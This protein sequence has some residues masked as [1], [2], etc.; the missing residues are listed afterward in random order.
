VGEAL[1]AGTNCDALAVAAVVE[2]EDV[3]AEVVEAREGWD[4]VG[5]GAVAVGEEEDS[6]VGVA[7]A[8]IG[9]NPPTGEL[10]DGGLIGT[11]ADEL[12]RNAGDRGWVAGRAG[13]VQD[14]L[15]LAL[16]EEQAKGEIAAE[17]CGKNGEADGLQPV[18]ALALFYDFKD[19]TPIGADGCRAELTMTFAFKN[20]LSAVLFEQ[21]FA[22]TVTSL[23]DAFVARARAQSKEP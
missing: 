9:G 6:Q 15:P 2:G 19:L 4:G 8:G 16:V 23:V 11:E 12:V 13:G 21:K 18:Q 17:E 10:R 14:E 3:G 22:E 7:G 20:A 5:E 1:L